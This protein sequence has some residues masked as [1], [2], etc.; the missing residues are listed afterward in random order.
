MNKK[1]RLLIPCACNCGALIVNFDKQGRA[2]KYVQGHNYS[3]LNTRFKKGQRI[4]Q[5]TEFKKGISPWNKGKTKVYSEETLNKMSEKKRGKPSGGLGRRASDES[6][7]KMS[8]S[9][10]GQ[11]PWNT[12]KICP[13]ISSRQKGLNNPMW[14]GGKTSLKQQIRQ[15]EKY[16]EW[17]H[18]CI[19]RDDWTCQECKIRGGKLHVDH[20]IPFAY[21][22]EFFEIKSIEDTL[23]CEELWNIENG[24]TLCKKCHKN[25]DTFGGKY[26]RWVKEARKGIPSCL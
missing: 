15:S 9:H 7:Q 25:T 20:V 13:N 11:K 12:G 26:H 17:Q 23:N 14:K 18:F 4:S 10:L 3:R 5:Q 24:R 22:L 19:E 8:L 16:V 1:E 21:I 6:K 2:R